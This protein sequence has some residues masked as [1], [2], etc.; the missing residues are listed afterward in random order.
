M[1]GAADNAWSLDMHETLLAAFSGDESIA[2]AMEVALLRLLDQDAY[3]LEQNVNERS[4]THRLAMYM[5]E[6]FR[7]WDV[8]A[9]YNRNHDDP[10]VIPRP[11]TIA[12]DDVNGQ[13]VFPDIIVHR[14]STDE[15][16]LVVEV[17]KDSNPESSAKDLDKLA[18]MKT[19]LGYTHALFI[20]FRVGAKPGVEEFL[21]P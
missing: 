7:D 11:E 5:Q 10:K 6:Q 17:K 21:V 19:A 15:N 8:D 4:I 14:R 12:T 20:R 2:E 16:L 3:L 1:A 18:R 13:T 9:E